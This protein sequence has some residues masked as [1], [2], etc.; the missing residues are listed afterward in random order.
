LIGNIVT[1][2][3]NAKKHIQVRQTGL[4]LKADPEYG[5]RVAEGLGLAIKN[6]EVVDA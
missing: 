5:R 6:G 3:C 4:F 2:L 1:H